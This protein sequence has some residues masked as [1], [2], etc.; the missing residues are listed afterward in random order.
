M[1][2]RVSRAVFPLVFLVFIALLAGV[3]AQAATQAAVV[4][5][6]RDGRV[7]Y[8][9]NADVQLHPASLTK[10]MTLY[11]VFEA[12]KRGELALGDQVLVSR[13][14]AAEPPSKL[15]L[16]EGTRISLHYLIRASAVKSANDA[17]TA[18]A[19]AVSGSVPEFAARMTTT[20]RA[21]G[22]RNTVFKNAH[23][24][25]ESGHYSTARDMALLGR[26]LFYD[27]P[28]YYNLFSRRTTDAGLKTVSNT[29]IRL[30]KGY[31]GADG[32][33]TGYTRAAGHNLVASA[34][35]GNQRVIVS[36]FGGTSSAAR[37]ETVSQLLDY[38]FSR[39]PQFARVQQP[40]PIAYQVA[41]RR[42]P[43]RSVSDAQQAQQQAAAAQAAEQRQAEQLAAQAAARAAQSGSLASGSLNGNMRP[44]PRETANTNIRASIDSAVASVAGQIGGSSAGK[45]APGGNSWGVRLGAYKQPQSAEE[46]LIQAA[47]SAPDQVNGATSRIQAVRLQGMELYDARFVGITQGHAAQICS[48]LMA[49]NVKCEPIRVN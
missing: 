3:R 48:A 32:I 11:V 18:L 15:G 40:R 45:A 19:E 28:Q 38:G 20:G 43:L 36:F 29:N 41:A 12:V 39:S 47:M 27:Y 7:L 25:T 10:M 49:Q 46:R 13:R 16:R 21:L 1:T 2:L 22:M 8:E 31:E 14:A 35:R 9:K 24:L 23:G 33:K 26:R 17:A 30:L 6:A 5:D 37:T 44:A 34:K 4:I 42:A